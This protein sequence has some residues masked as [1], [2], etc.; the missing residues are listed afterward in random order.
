LEKAEEAKNDEFG[1]QDKD[2]KL[3]DKNQCSLIVFV[4]GE[5]RIRIIQEIAKGF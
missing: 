2:Y 5:N 1:D 4:K 3:P